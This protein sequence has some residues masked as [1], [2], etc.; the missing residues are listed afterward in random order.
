MTPVDYRTLTTL[1]TGASAGLGE[2]F[3]RRLAARGSD[4]V[5]VARRADRL[6]KLAAD[7]EAAHRVRVTVIPM[8]LSEPGAGRRLKDETDKLGLRVTGL[9]NNAGFGT[10][11]YFQNE[12]AG[13]L[14]DEIAVNV[15]ALV[16]LSRAYIGDLRSAGTGILVNV[17]S[18]A[19]YQPIP[20][21][22]TY[23]ATKAFVLNFTEALWHESQGTGL[24]VTCLSPG[25]TDTE[26]FDVVGANTDGGTPRQSAA[27]V[28]STALTALD[29]RT[30]PPSV[31]SGRFN[32]V[33]TSASRLFPRRAALYVAGRML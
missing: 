8:D 4:L 19:A 28:V 1:I 3:A 5:L 27:Q 31:V 29:R 20:K 7:L 18:T 13:R 26:F 23:A 16:D 10:H 12:D 6:E 14:R 24:R 30:P 25:A 9:I 22:A 11:G 33:L 32:R 15:A 21:M 17:A 2:E